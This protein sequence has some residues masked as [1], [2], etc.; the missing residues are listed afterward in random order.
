MK[1]VV[2]AIVASTAI[3]GCGVSESIRYEHRPSEI[4]YKDLD[5]NNSV[6]NPFVDSGILITLYIMGVN[7]DVYDIGVEFYTKDPTKKIYISNV[8]IFGNSLSKKIEIKK[9]FILNNKVKGSE[10]IY[11]SRNNLL[12]FTNIDGKNLERFFDGSNQMH[13][14][15]T[16]IIENKTKKMSFVINKKTEKRVIF[17]T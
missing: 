14:E 9:M 4:F 3:T 17:P 12:R 8:Y 1:S 6:L 5:I 7:H 15:V 10:K 13:V 16:Y 2:M 11:E